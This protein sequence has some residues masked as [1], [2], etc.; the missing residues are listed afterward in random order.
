MKKLSITLSLLILF[1]C[2]PGFSQSEYG[3]EYDAAQEAKDK[4]AREIWENLSKL[5]SLDNIPRSI[6]I[7]DGQTVRIP[8]FMVALELDGQ[9]GGEFVTE[10][11]LVPAAGMC[12]HVPPPPANQTVHVNMK[13]KKETYFT[14]EP[15][16]VTGQLRVKKGTNQFNTSFYHMTGVAVEN[17]YK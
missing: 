16:W 10:F 1:V 11:L 7:L 2:S 15:V 3:A 5:T 13:N 9:P 8:G 14:W 4:E 6:E 17:Y 12:L